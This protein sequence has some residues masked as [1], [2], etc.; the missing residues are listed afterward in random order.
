MAKF[1]VCGKKEEEADLY[2]FSPVV[3]Y[4]VIKLFLIFVVQRN[5]KVKHFDSQTDFP[6][7]ELERIVNMKLPMHIFGQERSNSNII[8]IHRCLYGLKDAAKTW[9]DLITSKFMKARLRKMESVPRVFLNDD[10][11]V[12]RHVDDQPVV[13]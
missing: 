10:T 7:G 12:D 1:V 2:K 11:A 13:A 3:D 4:T 9:Y 6:T 5:L 8:S